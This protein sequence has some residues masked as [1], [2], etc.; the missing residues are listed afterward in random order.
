MP[1]SRWIII[2]LLAVA[3]GPSAPSRAPAPSTEPT[4]AKAPAAPTADQLTQHALRTL[5]RDGEAKA[6]PELRAALDA[7]QRQLGAS[8]DWID[9]S[10]GVLAPDD[11]PHARFATDPDGRWLARTELERV[12]VFS[13]GDWRRSWVLDGHAKG[14]RSLA[15][16]SPTRLWTSDGAGNVRLWD[17]SSGKL[18]HLSANND[19]VAELLV[20]TASTRVVYRCGHYFC[21][22]KTSEDR[23]ER[24]RIRVPSACSTLRHWLHGNIVITGDDGDELC[25]I[26]IG[27]GVIDRTLPFVSGALV[28]P[29]R[30]NRFL[31]SLPAARSTR[32]E[33][34]HAD[35]GQRVRTL[36]PVDG[37]AA[38]GVSPSL[39]PDGQKAVALTD[40]RRLAVWDT[41]T[42][43]RAAQLDLPEPCS[44]ATF[45][46]DG[47]VVLSH[48]SGGG[49]DVTDAALSRVE[50]AFSAPLLRYNTIA[51]ATDGSRFAAGID[52]IVQVW[53]LRPPSPVAVLAGES[54]GP[55]WMLQFSADGKHLASLHARGLRVW[56]LNQQKVTYERESGVG[57][58][59]TSIAFGEGNRLVS[60]WSVLA[61]SSARDGGGI[62]VTELLSPAPKQVVTVGAH[63]A[64]QLSVNGQRAAVAPQGK[65]V[66]VYDVAGGK[67]V[68]QLEL[69]GTWSLSSDG[70]WIGNVGSDRK[71]RLV[72]I[73]DGSSREIDT[74]GDLIGPMSWRPDSAVLAASVWGRDGK[75]EAVLIDAVGGAVT[76]RA[77]FETP[78]GAHFLTLL[79]GGGQ[80]LV[81][82]R[83]GG[84]AFH[85]LPDGERKANLGFAGDGRT[86][87][88][89][90]EPGSFDMGGPKK[91]ELIGCQIGPRV[92]PFALC[93]HRFRTVGLLA[94]ALDE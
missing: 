38:V 43:D 73:A 54:L 52:D 16:A 6:G 63:T 48:A 77:A 92:L 69:S 93:A 65:G 10:E 46:R 86:W 34:W 45:L 50:P 23:P 74:A 40:A 62:E 21:S 70:A 66:R 7:W 39:S 4:A 15:F 20:D 33:V 64:V 56:D 94:A 24:Q 12:T 71:L 29:M 67:L 42:G 41:S 58:R 11:V 8:V 30:G 80:F 1:S 2:A 76:S 59:I 22:W 78:P 18:V 89:W 61:P 57:T 53:S 75:V 32:I 55:S 17:L 83:T 91:D 72:R 60:T 85:R 14:A 82:Y 36:W 47:R 84:M 31:A 9:A 88:A 25:I 37:N 44:K 27:T 3:C 79:P 68:R 5:A 51:V 90:T 26:D 87:L 35:V 13:T 49:F 19:E 28:F 81:R